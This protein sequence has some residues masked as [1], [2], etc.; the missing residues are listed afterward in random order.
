VPIY[1]FTCAACGSFEVTRRVA[2]ASAPASCPRCGAEA[3]RVFTAPGLAL[4]AK[5]VRGVLDLQEKSAHA[6]AVVTEKRGR[7]LP[8]KHEPTP[9]WVLSH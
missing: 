5:P 8:H 7:A 2:E 9:P 4:L 1:A 3:R 6:P